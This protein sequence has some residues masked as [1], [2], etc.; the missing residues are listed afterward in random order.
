MSIKAASLPTLSSLYKTGQMAASAT[1][2]LAA[3]TASNL[4]N[5]KISL[6][7]GDITKLEVDAI[8][9][10]ANRGLMGGGGVDGAIHRAAGSSL[11]EECIKL[12]GCETG[13]AKITSAYRLPSKKV[14]H[15]VG[16]VYHD[17]SQRDSR[18]LLSSCYRSSLEL[19]VKEGCSSIAFCA[20]STGIYGYPSRDAATTAT[21][22][23][24]EY[25]TGP[26]GHKIGRVVFV[27]FEVKDV[28]SYESCL[29]IIFPP[30]TKK[31]ADGATALAPETTADPD[32]GEAATK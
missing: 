27:V 1:D 30:A 9:N 8:V 17:Q 16:P 13:K 6:W 25:L 14:I 19:A 18:A 28:H 7:K 3:Y 31:T 4:L 5:D 24:R 15:T 26:N 21:T 20:I 29:P 22:T 10:A 11:L 2:S 32:V 12:R 23:V